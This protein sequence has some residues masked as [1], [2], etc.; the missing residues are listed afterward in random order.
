MISAG[1]DVTAAASS[2]RPCESFLDLMMAYHDRPL[3]QLVFLD[4]LREPGNGKGFIAVDNARRPIPA[5]RFGVNAADDQ[6]TWDRVLGNV[7]RKR[8]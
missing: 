8:N 6:T 3:P 7:M 4:L 2:E 1:L 5:V